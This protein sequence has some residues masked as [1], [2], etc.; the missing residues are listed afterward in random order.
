MADFVVPAQPQPFLATPTGKF[1]VS[2][3][4]WLLKIYYITLSL[5]VHRIYCVGRNYYDHGIEMGGNP[6][7]EPPFFFMKPS[8]S[9]VSAQDFGR[10]IKQILFILNIDF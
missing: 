3:T 2:P 1:P 5:K 8:D 7:R 6:D 10:E 9:A 4:S